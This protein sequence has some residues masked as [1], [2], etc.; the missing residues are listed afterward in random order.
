M[1]H[2]QCG[3]VD[4][5]S[6]VLLDLESSGSLECLLFHESLAKRS[7]FSS[8]SYAISAHLLRCGPGGVH[9]GDL[10]LE[11]VVPWTETQSSVH[12]QKHAWDY[13]LLPLIQNGI[14]ILPNEDNGS[15]L[16]DDDESRRLE[17]ITS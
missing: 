12:S 3:T 1:E 14:L 16:F 6:F 4:S 5:V 10:A 15:M 7:I 9:S 13:H 2:N 17:P 11:R 8:V